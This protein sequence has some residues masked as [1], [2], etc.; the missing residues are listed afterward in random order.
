[1]THL[2]VDFGSFD[3]RWHDSSS[4]WN[5]SGRARFYRW[6]V[7]VKKFKIQKKCPIL[8]FPFFEFFGIT[9]HQFCS[10]WTDKDVAVIG[11]GSNNSIPSLHCV[12]CQM[13]S[14]VKQ[15][16]FKSSAEENCRSGQ[17]WSSRVINWKKKISCKHDMMTSIITRISSVLIVDMKW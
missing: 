11:R 1:M 10:R 6:D 15:L 12:R 9:S 2:F 4:F 14:Y 16:N 8:V 3:P 17:Q 7:G 13:S 5:C